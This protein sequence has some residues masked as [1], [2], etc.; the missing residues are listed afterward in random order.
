MCEPTSSTMLATSIFMSALSTGATYISQKEAAEDQQDYQDKVREQ[1]NEAAMDA[2]RF[3]T[4]Q[5]QTR[6]IQEDTT[7]ARET[8]KANLRVREEAGKA[9]ASSSAAGLSVEQIMGDFLRQEGNFNSS[10]QQ[11][12][13]WKSQQ[14][15]AEMRGYGAQ[16]KDRIA[17]YNPPPVSQPSAAAALATFGTKAVGAYG[18]YGGKS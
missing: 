17:S 9:M 12:M 10:L 15:E 8:Q 3:N 5:E 7:A 6:R 11:Q 18:K 2:Y 4:N 14:S 1:N 16:A 13:D